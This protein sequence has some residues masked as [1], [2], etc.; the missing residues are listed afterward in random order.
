MAITVTNQNEFQS[1][2]DNHASQIVI[3]G[4]FANKVLIVRATGKVSWLVSVIFF[5]ISLTILTYSPYV[6]SFVSNS[7]P[8]GINQIVEKPPIYESKPYDKN[9]KPVQK[10]QTQEQSLPG[11]VFI[12]LAI[13]IIF[14]GVA[15]F[16]SKRNK[17]HIV[18]HAQNH[19]VL[20]MKRH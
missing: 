3:E 15:L 19:L 1:A 13:S 18:E 17:Y 4:D 5:F 14:C 10:F 20:Q 2:V 12:T 16:L 9:L 8:L 11:V 7:P 6:Q